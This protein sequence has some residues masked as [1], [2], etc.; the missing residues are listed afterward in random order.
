MIKDAENIIPILSKRRQAKDYGQILEGVPTFFNLKAIYNFLTE[1]SQ[2]QKPKSFR[3]QIF[4][5]DNRVIIQ[6]SKKII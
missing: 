3:S 5:A 1:F 2:I 6:F 4:F